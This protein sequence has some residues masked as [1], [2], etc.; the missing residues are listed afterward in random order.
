MKA[1]VQDA[2]GEP[3]EVLKLVELDRPQPGPGEAVIDVALAPVHHGDVMQTRSTSS[4]RLSCFEP[5]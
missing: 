5:R 4:I 2:I 3:A 1:V